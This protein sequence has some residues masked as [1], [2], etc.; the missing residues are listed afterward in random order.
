M[1]GH[2][3]LGGQHIQARSVDYFSSARVN[4]VGQRGVRMA[5]AMPAHDTYGATQ[6]SEVPFVES[7]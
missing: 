5:P 7:C 3:L 2:V 1:L 6:L 4:D